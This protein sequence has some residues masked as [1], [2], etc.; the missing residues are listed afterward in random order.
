[1]HMKDFHHEKYK[2][3]ELFTVEVKYPR[4]HQLMHFTNKRFYK[5]MYLH[6]SKNF[7]LGGGG[8]FLSGGFCLDTTSGIH[9]M[10]DTL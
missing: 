4:L 2:I 10:Y 8:K 6:L 5:P 1:M 9:C 7:H 3:H